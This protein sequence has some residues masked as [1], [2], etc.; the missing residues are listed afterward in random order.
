MRTRAQALGL[1]FAAI[2]GRKQEAG[3][4]KLGVEPA[5]T[6]DADS[7]GGGLSYCVTAV[8]PISCVIYTLFFS[9]YQNIPN[10]KSDRNVQFVCDVVSVLCG[11]LCSHHP[12]L[13]GKS[14]LKYPLATPT[15]PP[16]HPL[17]PPPTSSHPLL[18]LPPLPT[19]SHPCLLPAASSRPCLPTQSSE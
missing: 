19:P 18:P 13:G 5:P 4:E 2:P 9:V 16:A 14:V 1:S 10:Q 12:F 17:P 3:L 6:W 15:H 7:T 11:F 8:A